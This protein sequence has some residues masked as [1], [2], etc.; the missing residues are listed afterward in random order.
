[1]EG[2]IHNSA[3]GSKPP[4]TG[5]ESMAGGQPGSSQ[6]KPSAA[7]QETYKRVIANAE[8]LIYDEKIM[9]QLM[10][11]I[12]GDGTNPSQG[13]GQATAAVLTKIEA[14]AQQAG[15][16]I[17]QPVRAAAAKRIIEMMAE[18]V[19]KKG[20]GVYDF[21][22]EEMIAAFY[23]AS[24][25]YNAAAAAGGGGQPNGQPPEGGQP[26]APPMDQGG[27]RGLMPAQQQVA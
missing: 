15:E 3:T 25:A 22:Q 13:L 11:A 2:L 14:A 9:P 1:M 19:G 16:Q 6:G 4:E 27:R 10:R 7:D 23:T 17:S 20:A 5:S 26:V 12:E 18:L 8:R 24:N 21:S